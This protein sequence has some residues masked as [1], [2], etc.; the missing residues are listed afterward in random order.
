MFQVHR[1]LLSIFHRMNYHLVGSVVC[2]ADFFQ[3]AAHDVLGE[4]YLQGAFD[5]CESMLKN[6]KV[7]LLRAVRRRSSITRNCF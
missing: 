4:M 3:K 5:F 7:I 1:Y 2:A 6:D